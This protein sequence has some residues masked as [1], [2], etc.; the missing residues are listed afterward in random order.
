MYVCSS[1]LL[2]SGTVSNYINSTVE[3]L[4]TQSIDQSHYSSTVNL[5]S[6]DIFNNTVR[7]GLAYMHINLY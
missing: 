7:Y 2:L 6:L 4:G 3:V 5:P 1:K